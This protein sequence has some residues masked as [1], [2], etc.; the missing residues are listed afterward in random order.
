MMETAR[1]LP[2]LSFGSG[3]IEQGSRPLPEEVAVALSFN[4]STQ[5]V[6]MATPADLTDFAYGFALTEGIATPDQIDSVDIVPA[7]DGIDVQVWL[8]EDAEKRLA[9]R[10][11][12]ETR[13]LLTEMSVERLKEATRDRLRFG[14]LTDAGITTVQSVLELGDRLQ[15]VPGIGATTATRMRGAAQT[16]WQ[17]TYDEM[18]TRIDIKNRTSHTTELLRC[19]SA[20]DA[21]RKTKGATADLAR[22]EELTPLA[23]A[24]DWKVTHVAVFHNKTEPLSGLYDDVATVIRRAHI[25]SETSGPKGATG[26]VD[27]WDDFLTRPADYFAL[28]AELGFIT[29]DEEKTHGDLSEDMPSLPD[30]SKAVSSDVLDTCLN[31]QLMRAAEAWPASLRAV[32]DHHPKVVLSLDPVPPALRTELKNLD[33]AQKRRAKRSLRDGIDRILVDLLALYRD[34]MTVQLNAQVPL[35]N[36]DLETEIRAL[37]GRT[38]PEATIHKLEA[39]EEARVRIDRNVRDQSALDAL[40]VSLQVRQD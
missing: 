19:L 32:V 9:A 6:M 12:A 35:V 15:Q 31:V 24:L 18:P 11:R 1:R 39:I 38:K 17:T 25:I 26:A 7:G 3:G 40:A 37:A 4:G 20:W 21:V 2:R 10:R 36:Q 28:L 22:V 33:E 14:P 34:V 8:A 5:A 23:R 29:E 30:R 13:A 16:L 27:P